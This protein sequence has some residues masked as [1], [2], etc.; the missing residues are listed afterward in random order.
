[1]NGQ[2]IFWF[3]VRS[4][5]LFGKKKDGVNVYEE[6]ILVFSGCD[7]E[8]KE[9]LEKAGDEVEQYATE[10]CKTS[11]FHP[12]LDAYLQDGDPLIEGYEVWSQLYESVLD[13]DAFWEA[14]HGEYTFRPD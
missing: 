7:A 9:A 3:G 10:I 5:C 4:L 2:D 8:G 11:V 1:M 14:R 12:R 13:I 6:R